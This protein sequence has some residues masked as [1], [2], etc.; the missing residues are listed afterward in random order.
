MRMTEAKMKD[1]EARRLQLELQ[2][3]RVQMEQNQ[4]ALQEVMNAHAHTDDDDSEQS[5]SLC[6]H[7]RLHAPVIS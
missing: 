5:E 4:K 2:D 3:A 1:D 7:C 6:C